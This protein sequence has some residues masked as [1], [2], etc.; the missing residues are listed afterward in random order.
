V[1]NLLTTAIAASYSLGVMA[2]ALKPAK[3]APARGPLV[4][5]SVAGVTKLR[6]VT[7]TMTR[8]E[9]ERAVRDSF[10][11]VGGRDYLAHL[12]QHDPGTYARYATKLI[13][14]RQEH[15]GLDG[16]AIRIVASPADEAL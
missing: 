16:G 11:M 1:Q 7:G 15:T 8:K 9:F 5:W 2:R 12:A 4:E 10:E 3:P 13:S 6:P 14:E